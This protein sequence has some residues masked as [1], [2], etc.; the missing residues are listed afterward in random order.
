MHSRGC[1]A[2]DIIRMYLYI[3]YIL[4]YCTY[5]WCVAYPQYSRLWVFETMIFILFNF[6]IHMYILLA[7]FRFFLAKW[8]R[9]IVFLFPDCVGRLVFSFIVSDWLGVGTGDR[10]STWSIY[11]SIEYS[12]PPRPPPCAPLKPGTRVL[13]GQC[14]ALPRVP[15]ATA[16]FSSRGVRAARGQQG[17]GGGFM[18][19]FDVAIIILQ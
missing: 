16:C 19:K 3:L 2:K 8:R 1:C 7:S 15:L 4:L 6:Y 9:F 18:F 5:D 13:G 14:L 12:T 10:L 17:P 11:L